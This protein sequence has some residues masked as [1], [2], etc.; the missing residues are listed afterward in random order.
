MTA[1]GDAFANVGDFTNTA[2]WHL[3]GFGAI[4][5]SFGDGPGGPLNPD[6]STNTYLVAFSNR[7]GI[8]GN[9]SSSAYSDP[10]AVI[11]GT[12]HALTFFAWAVDPTP[13]T[14]LSVSLSDSGVG[15][16]AFFSYDLIEIAEA[17]GGWTQ[18]TMPNY[19]PIGTNLAVLFTLGVPGTNGETTWLVDELR[20]ISTSTSYIG[21]VN[22]KGPIQWRKWYF[23]DILGTLTRQGDA[24]RNEEGLL[25]DYSNYDDPGRERLQRNWPVR[26]EPTRRQP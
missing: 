21:T 9:V 5:N 16:G 26:G 4:N 24:V 22:G 6:G 25:V 18:V 17:S 20:A 10:V 19:T 23:D 7:G 12:P 3:G 8:L 1:Y 15:G 13:D 2:R 11:S 14:R